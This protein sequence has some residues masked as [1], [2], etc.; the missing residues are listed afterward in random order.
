[1]SDTIALFGIEIYIFFYTMVL[2][3]SFVVRLFI[4]VI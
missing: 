1:M 2:F 3:L 4:F